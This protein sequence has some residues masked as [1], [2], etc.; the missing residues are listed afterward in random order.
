MGSGEVYAHGA[1]AGR[2]DARSHSAF[3]SEAGTWARELLLLGRRKREIADL[4]MP[5]IE[6]Q[7]VFHSLQDALAGTTNS[8]LRMRAT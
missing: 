3:G 5:L 8:Q 2:L 4:I 6:Q 1:V 7:P